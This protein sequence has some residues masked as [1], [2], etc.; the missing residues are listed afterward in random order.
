MLFHLMHYLVKVI[1]MALVYKKMH[2]TSVNEWE[3]CFYLPEYA[4]YKWNC[5]LALRQSSHLHNSFSTIRN[6]LYNAFHLIFMLS[7]AVIYI[8]AGLIDLL[9]HGFIVFIY[10]LLFL[11]F[12]CLLSLRT[13]KSALTIQLIQNHFVDEYD[14][15]VRIFLSNHTIISY[16]NRIVKFYFFLS[17]KIT[18]IEDSYRKQVVIGEYS[19]YWLFNN[20]LRINAY[21]SSANPYFIVVAVIFPPILTSQLIAN[22]YDR[23]WLMRI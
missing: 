11:I 4:P 18:Q 3:T 10:H 17:L 1:E 7:L 9:P 5:I 6:L 23:H 14:P 19:N 8:D 16:L 15:T 2:L 20:S 13:G 21:F 22:H 12:F